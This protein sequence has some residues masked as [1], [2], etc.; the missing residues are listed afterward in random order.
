MDIKSLIL[1]SLFYFSLSITAQSGYIPGYI[2]DNNKDTISGDIVYQHNNRLYNQCLFRSLDGEK[3]TYTPD[4]ISGFRYTD[5]KYFISKKVEGENVFLE[6][7]V[8]GKINVYYGIGNN[9]TGLYYIEKDS[10]KNLVVLPPSKTIEQIDFHNVEKTSKKHMGILYLYMSDVDGIQDKIKKIK[11]PSHKSM[12]DIAEY[13]HTTSCDDGACN[14]YSKPLTKTKFSVGYIGGVSYF[15]MPYGNDEFSSIVNG[16]NI[17]ISNVLGREKLTYRTGIRHYNTS[18]SYTPWM[19]GVPLIIEYP[20]TQ[21]ALRP[22]IGFGGNVFIIKEQTS[23]Y[24]YTYL[25]FNMVGAIGMDWNIKEHIKVGVGYEVNPNSILD[26]A[27][28]EDEFEF[29][30]MNNAFLFNLTYRL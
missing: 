17:Q 22:Y 2:I 6:F 18:N 11:N 1:V 27:L 4:D 24:E 14:I 21:K 23:L 5:S 19:I 20:F 15:K 25:Q 30:I 29:S 7:L 13:Y 8:Q 3:V 9:T 12:I 28:G 26:S 10:T 16:V